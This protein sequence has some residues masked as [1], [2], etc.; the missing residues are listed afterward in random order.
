MRKNTFIRIITIPALIVLSLSTIH[1]QDNVTTQ[2][3]NELDQERVEQSGTAITIIFDDSGSMNTDDKIGQ[4]KKAFLEWLSAVPENYR[5]SLIGLN[6]GLIVP[7]GRDNR[8]VLMAKVESIKASGGTPLFR[9][10]GEALKNIQDRRQTVSPFERHVVVVFTDGKES[11][12]HGAK[13]VQRQILELRKNQI[14]VAGIGFHGQGDYMKGVSTLYFAAETSKELKQGLL[15]VDAEIG[16]VSDIR[17]TD[18]DFKV[19]DEI[20]LNPIPE[21]SSVIKTK[22]Q[23]NDIAKTTSKSEPTTKDQGVS[24]GSVFFLL[25][26]GFILYKI[27]SAAKK[28]KS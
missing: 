28:F 19:M 25:I 2:W 1:A 16:D 20:S 17:I 8:E 23:T 6:A 4:A 10:I 27:V 9:T 11:S 12:K 26:L 7:M 5:L 3:L 24:L 15:K 13:G 22:K 14:E 21:P 18:N